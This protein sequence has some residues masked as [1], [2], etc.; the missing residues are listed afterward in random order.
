M[1]SNI[2]Q[3][4][5]LAGLAAA[6]PLGKRSAPPVSQAQGFTLVANITDPTQTI[7]DP[8]VNGWSLTGTHVGAGVNAAVLSQTP[9]S[10]FFINGTGQ[11]VSRTSTTVALPPITSS[12]SDGNP[13]YVPQGLQFSAVGDAGELFIG[14]NIGL[15]TQ[16]VG[17]VGGLRSAYPE[18]VGPYA[19]TYVVCHQSDPAYGRPQYNVALEQES[20]PDNCVAI[21]LLAQCADLP[22]FDGAEELN[23]INVGVECYDDVAAIDWTQY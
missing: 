6:S 15:G 7:F 22:A 11:D 16:G 10:V 8:S 19:G 2:F 20:V 12:D 9:G 17:I 13:V 5:L 18:L 14:L 1:P 3:L 23:I 21:N 4:S